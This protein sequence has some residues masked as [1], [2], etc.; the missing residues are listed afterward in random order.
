MGTTMF[1]SGHRL[2]LPVRPRTNCRPAGE[3]RW[4]P[5]PWS[6]RTPSRRYRPSTA[7]RRAGLT[8]PSRRQRPAGRRCTPK[9]RHHRTGDP[10]R[11][12]RTHAT[13]PAKPASAA[14][15]TPCGKPLSAWRRD[16]CVVP[17]TMR[18]PAR[19]YVGKMKFSEV[20]S[21]PAFRPPIGKSFQTTRTSGFGGPGRGLVMLHGSVETV[22]AGPLVVADLAPRSGFGGRCRKPSMGEV[23]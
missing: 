9:A 4:T 3:S 23:R 22:R 8:S 20:L 6:R 7:P 19:P 21:R 13:T 14:P 1:K 15:C 12:W 2:D 16:G 10:G 11:A 18:P 17:P 5:L